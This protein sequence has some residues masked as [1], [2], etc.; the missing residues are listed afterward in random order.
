MSENEQELNNLK[1]QV[2]TIKREVDALQIEILSSKK[3]W[4]RQVTT[5]IAI[6]ALLFSFGTTIVAYY[7]TSTQDLLASRTE[8]RSLLSELSTI[9]EQHFQMQKNYQDEPQISSELS[10]Q[11]NTRNLRLSKQAAAVIERIEKSL[12]G[13]G[14][15]LSVEYIAVAAGLGTSFQHE[16]AMKHHKIAA[17]RDNDPTTAAG[18][19]RSIAGMELINANADGARKFMQKARQ[20]FSDSRFRSVDQLTMDATNATTEVQWS[21]LELQLGECNLAQEHKEKAEL[22]ISQLP[23]GSF[24]TNLLGLI[25]ERTAQFDSCTASFSPPQQAQ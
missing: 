25:D 13:K 20:I 21:F 9:P 12:F 11:F 23:K 15:V 2:S 22:L 24:K 1:D 7:R 10:A 4:Y 16:E 6:G 3:P 17:S 5:I 18:T 19:L 8:L 14:T